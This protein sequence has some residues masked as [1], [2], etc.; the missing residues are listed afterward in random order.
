MVELETG[1]IDVS[2]GK[3]FE[4]MFIGHS[5]VDGN[6]FGCTFGRSDIVGNTSAIRTVME[7]YIFVS[8]AIRFG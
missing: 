1:T 8:P 5:H 4:R 7:F 3:V 2:N 6:N